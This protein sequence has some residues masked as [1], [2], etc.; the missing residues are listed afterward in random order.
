MAGVQH[1]VPGAARHQWVPQVGAGQQVGGALHL[2]ASH[3]ER[4]QL[5]RAQ[6]PLGHARIAR[7]GRQDAAPQPD[8]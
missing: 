1:H 2:L 8:R 6:D 5:V 4:L 7:I 3:A